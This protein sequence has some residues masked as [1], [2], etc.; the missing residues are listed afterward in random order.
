MGVFDKI[1]QLNDNDISEYI[2]KHSN[3]IRTHRAG[4]GF[5]I[6]KPKIIYDTLNKM[7]EGDIL[8]Y[9]DAGMYVNKKER[10]DSVFILTN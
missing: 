3:F 9:C 6:W 4:F 1:I 7:K 8:V 5:W 2:E 10:I